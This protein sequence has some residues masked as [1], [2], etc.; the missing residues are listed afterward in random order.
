VNL[1]ISPPIKILALIG[2]IAVVA[3]GASTMLLGHS[4][5]PTRTST[6]TPHSG[7]IVHHVPPKTVAHATPK[8]HVAAKPPKAHAT[9]AKPA[10]AATKTHAKH[11]ATPV[12][13]AARPAK[14]A[15]RGNLVYEDLP[16]PLQWQ[17]AQ[18]KVVVV[19]LY[20]PH[21]DVDAISV[22]EAHAGALDASAGFLL[23]NVL[24][25]KLAGP[26]TALLPGGG[27]LPDPGVLVYRAPGDIIVRLD[28]FADRTSIAQAAA[29]ALTA[30]KTV[31]AATTPAAAATPSA[32]GTTGAPVP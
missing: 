28:G 5:S 30:Q 10:T 2:L 22:A 24:D 31:P 16:A 17:L 6:A 7:R 18:H 1:T 9:A 19:S 13:H 21:A 25:D 27:L 15:P 29:N 26:L 23:V 14:P 12:R 32:P 3:F 8:P 11:A 20:N 4:S